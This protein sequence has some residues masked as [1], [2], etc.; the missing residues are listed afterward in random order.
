MISSNG[1]PDHQHYAN[2]LGAEMF[3]VKP[4][5]VEELLR[6]APQYVAA[7]PDALAIEP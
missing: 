1:S 5:A 7:S 6:T 4:I 2:A 3:L